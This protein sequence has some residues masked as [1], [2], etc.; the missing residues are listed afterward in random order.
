MM[1]LYPL[2]INIDFYPLINAR[3]KGHCI[4]LQVLRYIILGVTRAN[5]TLEKKLAMSKI[6]NAPQKKR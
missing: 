3:S 5:F 6:L 1:I 4:F 2:F